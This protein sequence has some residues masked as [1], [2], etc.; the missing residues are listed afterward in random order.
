MNHFPSVDVR[1]SASKIHKVLYTISYSIIMKL[2]NICIGNELSFLFYICFIC[3]VDN[4]DDI[5]RRLQHQTLEVQKILRDD[6][7]KLAKRG[8]KVKTL[9]RRSG[10]VYIFFIYNFVISLGLYLLCYNEATHCS[11]F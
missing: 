7:D 2:E 8:P 6:I 10:A 11:I 4:Q 9:A 5:I 3:P 1:R